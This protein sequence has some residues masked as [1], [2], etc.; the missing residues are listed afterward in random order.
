MS[1]CPP[2]LLSVSCVV[3]G[4][5]SPVTRSLWLKSPCLG[6]MPSVCP[7]VESSHP[8]LVAGPFH[9]RGQAI[10]TTHRLIYAHGYYACTACGYLASAKVCNLAHPCIP[11]IS[12]NRQC[13]LNHLLQ[14]LLPYGVTKWLSLTPPPFK[15]P[16]PGLVSI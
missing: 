2:A 9:V 6:L 5:S 3:G 4:P 15:P 1:S 12:P 8:K 16:T 14:G 13:V 11:E 10:H 7:P